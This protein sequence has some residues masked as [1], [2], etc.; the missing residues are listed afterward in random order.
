MKASEHKVDKGKLSGTLKLNLESLIQLRS[1][2]LNVSRS[3]ATEKRLY[4][5]EI[6]LS[7]KIKRRHIQTKEEEQQLQ[8]T[9]KG[10]AA[11]QVIDGKGDEECHTFLPS[12]GQKCSPR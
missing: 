4:F 12:L 11:K 7:A 2:R 8:S 9:T 5:K 6:A 1:D 10:K 3:L